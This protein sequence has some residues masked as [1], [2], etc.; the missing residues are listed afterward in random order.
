MSSSQNKTIAQSSS[1]KK[2]I[3]KKVVE[4]EP[5]DVAKKTKKIVKEEKVEVK[6]VDDKTKKKE[7]KKVEEKPKKAS[8]KEEK[9]EAPKE[10]IPKKINNKPTLSDTCGLN[11]SVAK[12]KNIVS[13]LCVNKQTY[14]ATKEMKNHRKFAN[15]E[16]KKGDFTFSLDGLSQSTLNYLEECWAHSLED[17]RVVHA[18]KFVKELG[19][20]KEKEYNAKKRHAMAEF[21]DLQ[22]ND[23]LFGDQEFDLTAFNLSWDP[24]FYD[25]MEVEDWKSYKDVELYDFCNTLVNKNKVR[26]N[27]EAKVFITAFVEYIIRQLVVNG[28]VNTVEDKKKIIKLEHALDT[29]SEG[30]SERFPLFPFLVN[31]NVY[32]KYLD[33]LEKDSDDEDDED[34]HEE[35]ELEDEESE[36]I[37]MNERQ[38]QF[39][40]YV[41]ELCRDV[42]ME[43]AKE[44]EEAE[45]ID[46]SLYNHTS[47]SKDFKQFCSDAIVELL[48]IFGE[49]LLAEVESRGVK[50]INYTI[51]RTLIQVSHRLY[52]LKYEETVKFI[53]QCYTKNKVYLKERKEK[54]ALAPK[55]P[56]ADKPAKTV[57]ASK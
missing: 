39:K 40:Y 23:N 30:F 56:K 42:R 3:K 13:N 43:L 10:K 27:P 9:E 50:T 16:E 36:E 31:L 15:E 2:L 46:S 34:D 44:D 54:R 4:K 26:F 48:H 1:S 19:K 38:L 49:T 37:E 18:R 55:T 35:E 57:K 29:D 47:V 33:N 52:N 45:S 5:V 51:V 53:Q 21:H 20:E 14:H 11:L 25:N 6:K 24:K 12:V 8:K 41:A 22:K 7:T 28:T 32:K 17:T